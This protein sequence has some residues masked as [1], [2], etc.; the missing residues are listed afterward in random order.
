MPNVLI[1][2]IISIEYKKYKIQKKQLTN[3][4]VS[5]IVYKVNG[6]YADK[7][8]CDSGSVGGVQP[9]Q[10]WGRGFESRLSLSDSEESP[11]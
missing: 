1:F 2:E 8:K 5:S 9:C 4:C 6:R 3:C 11:C 7:K 10:G